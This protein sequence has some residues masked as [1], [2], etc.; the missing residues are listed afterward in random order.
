MKQV[1]FS[2]LMTYVRCPEHYLFHYVLKMKGPPKK[3]FK[4]GFAMHETIAY[5][6]SQKKLDSKGLKFSEAKEFFLDVFE[7]AMQDYELELEEAKSE[8]TKEYLVKEQ[9]M[10]VA[11]LAVSGVK[12][13]E[14]YL[15]E[16]SPKILP[17]LIEEP[18]NFKIAE[19]IELVGRIDL[20]DKRGTIHELKTSRNNPN[21]QDVQNDPQLAIYQ[22]AYEV[23]KKK[24]AKAI[25]K[26]YIVLSKQN[27]K[28]VR[29]EIARPL[30]NK[31]TVIQNI[32]TIME[33]ASRNIFYCLHPAESWICSKEWCS[34]YKAHQELK[35]IGLAKFIA[36]YK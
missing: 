11:D 2:Q 15:R 27:P 6:F 24:P 16:M 30:M 32:V 18:F 1:S 23:L 4:H 5:H 34:Y 31:K 36:K 3:V 17:D 20:T 26:D 29:F 10:N 25:S 12:G 35:K 33:A 9:K 8:L 19:G 14:V 28:I 22:M 21:K 13:I 7:K